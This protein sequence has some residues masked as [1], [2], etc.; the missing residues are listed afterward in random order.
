MSHTD[1]F[2]AHTDFIRLDTNIIPCQVRVPHGFFSCSLKYSVPKTT[3]NRNPCEV[4]ASHDTDSL[5][6]SVSSHGFY[7][8]GHGYYSVSSPC[9]T[10]IFSCSHGF[11]PPGH[12]FYSVSSPCLTWILFRVKSVSSHGFYPPGHG[13][14]S[15][16]SPC[17]T[18]IFFLLIKIFRAK[19]Y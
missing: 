12:G 14:Y 5:A 16:S 3:I 15:V 7:P 2:P 4:R 8:P 18:R 11:Y 19:N 10:R 1:F 13:F 9:L 6:Y 17:L